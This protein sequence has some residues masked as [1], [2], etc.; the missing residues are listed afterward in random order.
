M[1]KDYGSAAAGSI[2]RLIMIFDQC[3]Y[4]RFN[5]RLVLGDD[6]PVYLVADHQTRYNQ[7]VFAN[8]YFSSALH[9]I[10]HWCIAGEAR[11]GVEDYGYWYAPDGR[12]AE[13]QKAFEKVEVKPQ[14]LE[15]IF[16]V[17]AGTRFRISVDNLSGQSTDTSI[18]MSAVFDQVMLYCDQ[19]LPL[20]ADCFRNA[21]TD[22]F[23]TPSELDRES[24]KLASLL[25]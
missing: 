12:T 20:R 3:F 6:E 14:A 5:T 24:F 9:E 2:D 23:D 1:L 16:S 25:L 11:R 21:L 13:Q 19:G 10:A 18:F 15:W 17:A 4:E 22:G 8:G 7:V